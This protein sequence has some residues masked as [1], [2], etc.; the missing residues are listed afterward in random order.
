MSALN[1]GLS[2]VE[3][4]FNKRARATPTCVLKEIDENPEPVTARWSALIVR[5]VH[6]HRPSNYEVARDKSPEP[7]VLTI[8]AIV[9]H[10]KVLV[11]G[12]YNL[13]AVASL[14]EHVVREVIIVSAWLVI[15]VVRFVRLAR[16]YVFD[17][18]RI[19]AVVI[20]SLDL[21]FG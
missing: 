4:L 1:D 13:F 16:R 3:C 6:K 15:D 20:Y 17:F 5:P 10:H 7:A 2:G 19:F 21:V 11:S 14:C 12:N 9:A 18:K 8:I